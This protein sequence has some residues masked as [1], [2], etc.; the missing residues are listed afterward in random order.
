MRGRR[1]SNDEQPKRRKRRRFIMNSAV[2]INQRVREVER[3]SLFGSSALTFPDKI[4]TTRGGMAT[5]HT[6]QRVVLA[7]PEFSRL[8]T[9]AENAFGDRSSWNIKANGDYQL[10]KVFRKFKNNPCS[11]V[12]YIFKVLSTGKYK[13]EIVN[14]AEN[15]TENF[16]FR[17][18]NNMGKFVEGDI[19]PSGT[20]IAQS[21]SYVDDN[22]CGGVN[23]R[24]AYTIL[25]EL[26]EDSIIISDYLA[27]RLEYDSVY[28]IMVKVNKDA[29]FLN[30]YGNDEY[31]K[32][33]PDIGEMT[34][35]GILC[36]IREDS[37][38]SSI[39]ETRVFH[40]NDINAYINGDGQ[41]VDI[42][43]HSNVDIENEQVNFY[44]SQIREWYSDIYA[45]IAPI[46]ADPSQ[47][48][49]TLLD[50]Y[51]KADKFL[52]DTTWVTKQDAVDTLIEFTVVHRTKIRP[53]QKITGRMG[54]K[55]VVSKIVPRRL[56]PVTMDYDEKGKPIEG[57]E[58]PIDMLA[59]GFAVLNRIISFATY[60]LSM[61]AHMERMHEYIKKMNDEGAS[62]DE[63]VSTVVEFT[64]IYNPDQGAE[65]ARL[66]R[67]E[68]ELVFED[69]IDNGLY[70]QIEPL[71]DVC[72][73]DAIIESE[74]RYPQAI[75]RHKIFSKLRHRW[76]EVH[77]VHH[78]GY[79]YIWVLKQEPTKAMSAIA[80]GR[81]TWYDLP[82]K[83]RQFKHH[84]RRYSDN[85]VRFGEYDTYNFLAGIGVVDFAK[86]S[87][88][89]RGSQYTDNSILASHIEDKPLDLT[90]YNQFPQLSNLDNVL[91]LMGEELMPD[92]FGYSTVGN[93]DEEFEVMFNNVK[94][95]ISIPDLRYVLIMHSYYLQYIEDRNIQV[96]D[97]SDFFDNIGETDLF[98]GCNK[99]Y[100]E[101]VYQK[102]ASLLPV[103]QQL[104][105]YR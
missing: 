22:Y 74:D 3:L 17:M 50:I 99:D 4:S 24:M 81:T 1:N 34:T 98:D 73:R 18:N 13:C 92:I 11:P 87:T 32:P 26:T 37:Y 102:F 41:L 49:T 60:E 97:L 79:Q 64:S 58:R 82:V 6:S 63:I 67:E 25:P 83:T 84:L 77:D 42:N 35:D 52:N 95:N 80:T 36:S 91:K 100:V 72:I 88:Y 38:L 62:R 75:K 30:R 8:Y 48:D 94:V 57:T 47:D 15:L 105:Q 93:V 89:Y 103:L 16:G 56:M 46:I 68:P 9:G 43:I 54:N 31:Y 51:H 23:A 44:L 5:K 69:I 76:V 53:G 12:A 59:N 33:F 71:N 27:E 19:I 65:I 39:T 28:K 20:P 14:P 86:L 101:I 2:E 55:S 21:S 40:S 66:Y 61:T 7:N 85:P 104:K 70:L 78:V 45:Y 10:M 96:T 29:F 90:K